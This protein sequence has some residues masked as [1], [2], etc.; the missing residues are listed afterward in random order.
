[1]T[2]APTLSKSEQSPTA[3]YAGPG[4]YFSL[5]KPRVMSLVIFTALVGMVTA[6]ANGG[7][8]NL[9]LAGVSLLSIAVGAGAS[10]RAEHVV[11]RRY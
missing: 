2:T 8:M 1:M 3:A 7:E 11:G 5:L 9:I 10:R 4:D 6:F